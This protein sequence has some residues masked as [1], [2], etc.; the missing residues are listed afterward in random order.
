MNVVRTKAV[1][2]H[3]CEVLARFLTYSMGSSKKHKEK[4]KDRDR[5]KEKRREKDRKRDRSEKDKRRKEEREE[6]EESDRS[7][8]KRAKREEYDESYGHE[9]E[10]APQAEGWCPRFQEKAVIESVT[11]RFAY[12]QF[13]NGLGQFVSVYKLVCQRLRVIFRQ[14]FMSWRR[15]LTVN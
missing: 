12:V 4:D 13:G 14:R 11:G 3:Y 5:S 6:R 10:K 2:S 1:F 15:D 8:G 7:G 9:T